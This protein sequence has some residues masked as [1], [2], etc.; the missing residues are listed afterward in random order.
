MSMLFVVVVTGALHYTSKDKLNLELGW[1]AIVERG[2]MLCLNIFHNIHLHETR[3]L[4][5]TCM[6]KLDIEKSCIT[7]SKGGYT[8]FKPKDDKCNTSFFVNTL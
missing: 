4:V 7:R 3:P 5:R 1:E 6:P 2:N 8:P